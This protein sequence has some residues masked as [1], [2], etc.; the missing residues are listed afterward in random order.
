[1]VYESKNP[2]VKHLVNE[3]RDMRIDALRFRHIVKEVTRLMLYETS[4]IFL[5]H[6]RSVVTWQGKRSF[7]FID[8]ENLLFAT[9]LRAGMPM[10]EAA[11][12]LFPLTPF[13]FLAMKRD[14]ETKQ[15]HLYYD[16]IPECAGKTVILLDVM[17]ATGGS[18]IDAV[19]VLKDKGASQIY[20]VNI[21]GAPEG[22]EVMQEAHPDVKIHIAQ[23][24]ERLNAEKFILPGLGDAGDRSYNTVEK[25]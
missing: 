18:L 2:L 4:E 22:L 14:E 12:E 23:I 16:R 15:S 20:S 7:D 25:T 5:L 10:L 9:V 13:G 24:D 1:M 17:V 21:I 3:L 8:Q 19:S 6:Q 11:G